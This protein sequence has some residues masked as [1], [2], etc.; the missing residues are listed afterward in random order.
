LFTFPATQS[1]VWRPTMII[2]LGR[3]LSQFTLPQEQLSIAQLVEYFQ[4]FQPRQC[5]QTTALGFLG[6]LKS[7]VHG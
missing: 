5:A 4:F 3:F 2:S 1:T 7:G 6:S